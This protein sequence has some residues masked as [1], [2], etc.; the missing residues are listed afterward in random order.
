M[1]QGHRRKIEIFTAGCATCN[2]TVDLVKRIAGPTHDIEIH[3]MF[4]A[5]MLPRQQWFLAKTHEEGLKHLLTLEENLRDFSRKIAER[6]REV[7]SDRQEGKD[8]SPAVP[9]HKVG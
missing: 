5:A 6:C 1:I 2:E 3:D 4:R 9:I 8:N 7:F